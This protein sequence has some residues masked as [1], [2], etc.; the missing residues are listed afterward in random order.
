MEGTDS[1]VEEAELLKPRL[2]DLPKLGSF[3]EEKAEDTVEA[4]AG[5]EETKVTDEEEEE[6]VEDFWGSGE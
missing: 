6:E 4:R 3:E 5:T 1:S 2:K